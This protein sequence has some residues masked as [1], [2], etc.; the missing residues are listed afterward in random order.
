MSL[1]V[2]QVEDKRKEFIVAYLEEKTSMSESCYKWLY[3]FQNK[4][5]DVLK[6]QS[7]DSL[8]K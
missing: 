3:R 4:G 2:S 5:F 6:N 8:K 7:Y 1:G